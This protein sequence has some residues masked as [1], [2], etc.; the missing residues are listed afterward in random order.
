[1]SYSLII[2]NKN[3]SSWS[4]RA[5]LL[6]K[7]VDYPFQEKIIDLYT[8]TSRNEAKELGGETGLVPILIND[9]FSIW[10]TLAITEYL[11]ES[12][13]N[14]WPKQKELRA[15]ARS[16]CGEVHSGL[17][18]LRDAMPV[19]TRARNRHAKIT[20]LVEEDIERVKKIWTSCLNDNNGPWLFGD[21][22][23]ADIFFAPIATRF[24]T[25]NVKLGGQAAEYQQMILSHHLIKEWMVLGENESSVIEQFE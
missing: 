11:Y 5:W 23:A 15:R 16:I 3:Y 19:N 12:S 6:M 25:Y 18:A 24:Q 8:N 17:N 9:G 1:M 2:G 4:M 13:P 20:K 21:F 14:L 22:C 7:F 10:D